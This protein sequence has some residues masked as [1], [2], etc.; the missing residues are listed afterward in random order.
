MFQVSAIII[1]WI[2]T[3]YISKVF[4]NFLINFTCEYLINGTFIEDLELHFQ[5]LS[6][7]ANKN[8]MNSKNNLRFLWFWWTSNDYL[9]KKKIIFYF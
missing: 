1:F 5:T 2:K 7:Y 3:K 8:F 4:L 9:C 6:V